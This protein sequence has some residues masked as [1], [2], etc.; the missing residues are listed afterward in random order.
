MAAWQWGNTTPDERLG[1]EL[2]RFLKEYGPYDV[3]AM[4]EFNTGR[5]QRLT[6]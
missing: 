3:E 6:T 1:S 5:K 4:T 2:M